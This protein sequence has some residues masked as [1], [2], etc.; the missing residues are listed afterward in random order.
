MQDL[1]LSGWDTGGSHPSK[2]AYV[3]T[4]TLHG[5]ANPYTNGLSNSGYWEQLQVIWQ[6]HRKGLVTKSGKA[7]VVRL[8][9]PRA[10]LVFHPVDYRAGQL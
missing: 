10:T 6:Q 5:V 7:A 3:R 2:P 8:Q 4:P 9:V 1:V